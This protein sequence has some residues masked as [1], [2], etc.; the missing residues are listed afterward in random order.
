MLRIIQHYAGFQR[1]GGGFEVG[2]QFAD[3]SLKRHSGPA[4]GGG[5][6][7]TAFAQQAG[8][9]LRV[10]NHDPDRIEAG[11]LEQR[12]GCR[13]LR[14][15]AHIQLADV[16]IVRRAH[17]HAGLRLTAALNA[18]DNRFRHKL[19]PQ[20]VAGRGG[21]PAIAQPPHRQILLLRRRP[22]RD[23]QLRQRLVLFHK[24]LGGVD[25]KFLN[26]T[27]GQRRYR[28]NAPLING[29]G[30]KSIELHRQRLA[31]DV[32]RTDAK[33]LLLA[34]ANL[35][36]PGVFSRAFIGVTRH[37]IHIHK[38]RFTRFIKARSGGHWIIPVQHFATR[39][40]LAAASGGHRRASRTQPVAAR[41]GKGDGQRHKGK[42]RFKLHYLT[43]CGIR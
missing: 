38:R 3:G 42:S 26:Q 39:F 31:G 10:I 7:L 34:G 16:A 19:Q 23:P 5:C 35:H 9:A 32:R 20:A 18:T 13:D 22:L 30:S 6:H 37:Q 12:L 28:F 33:V 24:L 15:G 43:S 11:Q 14:A 27:A 4:A 8:L 36:A 29:H 40:R 25:V 21:E 17:R 2:K 41:G 1:T